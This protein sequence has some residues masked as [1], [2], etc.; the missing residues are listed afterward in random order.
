MNPKQ[1]IMVIEP[2]KGYKWTDYAYDLVC[3]SNDLRIKTEVTVGRYKM[4]ARPGMTVA[5][6]LEQFKIDNK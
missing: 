5:M 6:V 3:I 4:E 1:L 2:T